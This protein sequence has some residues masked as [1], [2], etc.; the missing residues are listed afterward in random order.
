MWIGQQDWIQHTLK[1]CIS[2]SGRLAD[3][4]IYPCWATDATALKAAA[5]QALAAA[6]A[7]AP[8]KAAAALKAAT[9][10]VAEEEEQSK[11]R[12]VVLV[13][14]QTKF[15]LEGEGSRELI[16]LKAFFKTRKRRSQEEKQ[17]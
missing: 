17:L 6:D 10:K 15:G 2:S 9:K 14:K 12:Y 7:A 11:Q 5:E 16:K 1:R 8:L 3:V 4:H 13:E